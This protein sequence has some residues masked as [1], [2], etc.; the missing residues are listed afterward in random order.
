M[1]DAPIDRL[2]SPDLVE[3]VFVTGGTMRVPPLMA[4][5]LIETGLANASAA[6]KEWAHNNTTGK[7]G[8]QPK[9]G[10]STTGGYYDNPRIFPL[11]SKE[12][13]QSLSN[14][15][16][17]ALTDWVEHS[18]FTLSNHLRTGAS[19]PE[20]DK[21]VGLMDSAISRSFVKNKTVVM[22]G[23]EGEYADLQVGDVVHDK[24]FVSTT[25]SRDAAIQFAGYGS[26]AIIRIS[27]RPGQY[28]AYLT[29]LLPPRRY[30]NDFEDE[31]E[32]L[33]PRG[34]AIRITRRSV[35]EDGAIWLDA[36]VEP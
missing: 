7:K 34:T 14:D 13:E 3:V 23:V 22:R 10:P 24:S 4:R 36:T 32:V 12:W 6:F 31:Q 16:R 30:R 2:D 21:R 18:G 26:G 1:I 33:L 20:L 19:D 17:L 27:L 11:E 9:A 35:D 8:F 28:A 15:E 25:L 5:S 29:P